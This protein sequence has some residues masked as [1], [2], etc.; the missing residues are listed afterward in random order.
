M[1]AQLENVQIHLFGKMHQPLFDETNFTNNPKTFFLGLSRLN[2]IRDWYSQNVNYL[3][4]NETF[5]F[6]L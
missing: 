2:Y 1:S 5:N 6:F 3:I 4:K